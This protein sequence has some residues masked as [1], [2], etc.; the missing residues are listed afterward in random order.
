VCSSLKKWRTLEKR[1]ATRFG[2][3]KEKNLEEKLKF[4]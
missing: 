2:S 1:T 4:I 3:E